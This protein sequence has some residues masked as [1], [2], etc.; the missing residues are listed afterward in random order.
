M[1]NQTSIF[2]NKP[3]WKIKIA[4]KEVKRTKELLAR[5][6]ELDPCDF[7]WTDENTIEIP[8]TEDNKEVWNGMM[9]LFESEGIELI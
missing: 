6:E 1:K 9:I 4:L 7:E 5:N 3:T 8:E 2:D